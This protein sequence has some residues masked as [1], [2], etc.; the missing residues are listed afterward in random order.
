[1]PPPGAAWSAARACCRPP[2]SGGWRP[3]TTGTARCPRRTAPGSAWSP[4]PASPPS[5]RGS[6]TRWAARSIT[7]DVFGTAPRE[8]TRV[9]QPAADPGA[10]PRRWSTWSRR[11][12][13]S[14]PRPARS[15]G[16]A[17]RCCATPARSPS[18][19]PRSTPRRPRPA[20]PG[21]PGWRR[22]WSTPCC[23]ARPTTRAVPGRGAGLGHGQPRRGGGRVG[24]RRAARPAVVDALRRARRAA[25]GRRRWRPCRA[26]G[27]WCILG[28][29]E[30]AGSTAQSL[31]EHF[32]DGPVVV[33]PDRARTCSPPAGRRGPPWPGCAPRRPGRTPRA[34]SLADDLLPERVLA[35]DEHARRL[36]VDRVYRPLVAA[37]AVA[38]RDRCAP[39]STAAARSRPPRGCCSSTPT[40][41]ATGCGRIAT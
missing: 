31:A 27:W 12:S 40:P 33:G 13:P 1:M 11:R 3:T 19:P 36:L 26:T 21:T 38:A 2:P 34:R 29:V 14:W 7:A 18:P 35:G 5:S 41:C 6:A 9:D 25:A 37:G 30:D 10:G 16:C 23:A 4:R 15:R 32:G 39:T 28:G 8:L 17:R 22:W 20:A 24:A